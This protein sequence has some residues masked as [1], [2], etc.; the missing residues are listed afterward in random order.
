LFSAASFHSGGVN[1][2]LMDGSGR[3][4]SDTIESGT[5]KAFAAPS[6]PNGES[7]FG[8]WGAMGSRDGGESKSL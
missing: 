5:A 8:V 1:A 3:F 2:A 4:V 6:A 7:P